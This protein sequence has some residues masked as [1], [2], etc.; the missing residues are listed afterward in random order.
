MVYVTETND[1]L[2]STQTPY[3]I[4]VGD[5][6]VG[7]LDKNN[8]DWIEV[9]LTAGTTYTAAMAGLGTQSSA[10]SDPYLTLYSSSGTSISID[11]D[12]GP[13]LY[14]NLTFTPTTTDTYYISAGS[15][16]GGSSGDYAVSLAVGT[17]A[18]YDL[19]MGSSALIRSGYT[20][21]SAPATGASITWGFRDSGTALDADGKTTAFAQL[22]TAQMDAATEVA[23]YASSLSN[24]TL[25]QVATGGTTNSATILMA[26]YT[27]TTDGAGAYAYFPGSTATSNTA[28]DLW[29]NNRWVSTSA[30]P[31]GGYSYFVFLHEF[32]HAIG[33]SHPGDY[34]A[35]AGTTIAYGTNAQFISDSHQYS[36]MSYFDEANTMQ[37]MG[38]YP[39]TYMLYDIYALQ[40][41]YGVNTS[42]NSGD[43]VYGFNTNV[44]GVFDF[45]TNDK[46]LLSIWDG[47]GSDT[48]DLSGFTTGQLL[49][50]NDGA[51]SN[52]GGY[53]GNV[54]IAYGAVIENGIGGTA[55]D[56]I[57]GNEYANTIRGLSGNDTIDG[58]DGNDLLFGNLNHDVINAGN[59]ADDVRAGWGNDTLSGGAGDDLMRGG[60]GADTFVYDAGKD[61]IGDFLND[62]DRL[63]L[64]SAALGLDG[65]SAQEVAAMAT[66][67]DTALF[68]DF[69]GGNTLTLDDWEDANDIIDDIYLF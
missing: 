63:S 24:L 20:W 64:N 28:G 40:L 26:G 69:G 1:A 43:S 37:N 61:R 67:L 27:S 36:V 55:A 47:D 8:Q 65:L 35:A 68:W 10:V 14:S 34:N 41:L 33:L 4:S 54:S 57:N 50:L 21:S 9:T 62:V 59:G 32:G 58:G 52:I 31:V 23:T 66:Q 25:T 3:A 2:A 56:T 18:D 5:Y 53:D 17:K 48:I 30:L 6:F 13:G 15:Y 44:G 39:Q 12:S 38:L 45:S 46:P 42:A 7:Y 22:T 51:F 16:N 19:A 29:V 49:D 60:E 11:D